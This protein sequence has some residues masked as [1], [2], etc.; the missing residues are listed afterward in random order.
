MEDHYDYS[1]HSR[2]RA[3]RPKGVGN[4]SPEEK[5]TSDRI[6]R[7]YKRVLPLLSKEQREYVE[8]RLAGASRIDVEIELEL[9]ITQASAVWSQ[10]ADTLWDG[11]D[12]TKEFAD[13]LNA[14]RMTV[15]DL[16]DVRRLKQQQEEREKALLTVNMT[17][18]DGE[19]ERIR[20]LLAGSRAKM[21]D[22]A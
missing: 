1:E 12:L 17:D 6:N 15:K 19:E 5:Q 18:T 14:I 20:E 7:M 2:R 22:E 4:R 8:K 9:L 16:G 21:R 10:A 11:G 13:T 3:G